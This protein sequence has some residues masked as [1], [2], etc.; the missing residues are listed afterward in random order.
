MSLRKRK[1]AADEL[2]DDERVK[3]LQSLLQEA[4][5]RGGNGRIF[6]LFVYLI[7]GL[8]LAG[9]A[10]A[11]YGIKLHEGPG[12][13]NDAEVFSITNKILFSTLKMDLEPFGSR[14]H[15]S[16]IVIFVY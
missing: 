2:S 3:R 4:P 8:I 13:C 16:A 10:Y 15:C 11:Q 6:D 12:N 1:G 7:F 5:R 14:R 9:G